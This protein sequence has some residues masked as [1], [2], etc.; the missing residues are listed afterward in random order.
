MLAK[1]YAILHTASE[2]SPKGQAAEDLKLRSA[3]PEIARFYG[4]KLSWAQTWH[5]QGLVGTINPR[6]P[7]G[8]LWAGPPS[9]QQGT[10]C[11]LKIEYDVQHMVACVLRVEVIWL[12]AQTIIDILCVVILTTSTRNQTI[13]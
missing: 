8:F 11:F 2:K 13:Q 9:T 5:C 3:S 10:G 1:D 7:P 4:L 12:S 6:A